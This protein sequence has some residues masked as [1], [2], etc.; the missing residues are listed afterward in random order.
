MWSFSAA[1]AGA[2]GPGPF[3]IGVHDEVLPRDQGEGR[4]EEDHWEIWPHWETAGERGGVGRTKVAQETMA[5]WSRDTALTPRFG[6]NPRACFI[7]FLY[8]VMRSRVV[9]RDSKWDP[10]R[11]LS[12]S[13]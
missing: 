8:S 11:L 6:S 10:D 3:T 9:G 4:D 12:Q 5:R 13:T 1:L 7:P 2:A